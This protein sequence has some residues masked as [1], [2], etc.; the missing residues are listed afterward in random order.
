MDLQIRSNQVKTTNSNKTYIVTTSGGDYP[1]PLSIAQEH[2]K[3]HYVNTISIFWSVGGNSTEKTPL[4][5][6]NKKE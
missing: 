4:T 1:L 3:R 2:V 6:N 5:S